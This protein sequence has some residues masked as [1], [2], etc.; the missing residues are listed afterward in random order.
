MSS[1]RHAI[2]NC[3][4]GCQGTR[5]A[6]DTDRLV[7]F[8]G[9]RDAVLTAKAY[10]M[11]LEDG[12]RRVAVLERRL[13]WALDLLDAETEHSSTGRHVAGGTYGR[14]WSRRRSPQETKR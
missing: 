2:P 8:F 4:C 10:A 14:V 13:A 11:G 1:G 7:A 12:R 9:N 5:G 3:P 6:S